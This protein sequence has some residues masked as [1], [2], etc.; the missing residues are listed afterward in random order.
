MP[1][2]QAKIIAVGGGSGS[3]K[4]T[5]VDR[6]RGIVGD[7][8]L[9]VLQMDHYYRDLSGLSQSERDKKNFDHPD[10][11]DCGMLVGH[12]ETLVAGKNIDRPS[13]DFA[14]HTRKPSTTVVAPRPVI[15]LDGILAL[16][17]PDIRSQLDLSIFV[18]VDDDVRFIRRLRRDVSQRGR[19]MDSVMSQ[20]LASVKPMHDQYVAPQKQVADIIVNWM[21]YND[22]AVAMV[23]ALVKTWI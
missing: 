5:L 4:T 20:Y 6:L 11:I 1:A 9:L 14:T 18:D 13:Y 8:D 19:T 2:T 3:G 16:H 7:D 21:D 12:L 17:Y 10:A 22:G 23:A 15:V